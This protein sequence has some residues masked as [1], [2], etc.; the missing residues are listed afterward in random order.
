MAISGGNLGFKTNLIIIGFSA[1]SG[2]C[3]TKRHRSFHEKS[4]KPP[5]ETRTAVFQADATDMKKHGRD[6]RK[7][8]VATEG[9]FSPDRKTFGRRKRSEGSGPNRTTERSKNHLKIIFWP[10]KNFRS[11]G[12]RYRRTLPLSAEIQ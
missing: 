3:E 6:R 1:D 2:P 5:F 7:N 11:F 10:W 9:N 12:N 8:T 4:E